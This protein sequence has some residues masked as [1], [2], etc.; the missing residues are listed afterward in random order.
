MLDWRRKKRIGTDR[1]AILSERSKQKDD[2]RDVE[3]WNFYH[4]NRNDGNSADKQALEDA[5]GRE[6]ADK[7]LVS[8]CDAEARK[9]F[10]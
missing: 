5:L 1:H 8:V 10:G 3:N 4:V 2:V 7:L 9:V 6:I